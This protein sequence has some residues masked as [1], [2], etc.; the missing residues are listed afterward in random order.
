VQLSRNTLINSAFS[1]N[2][3]VT[4]QWSDG[5]LL[6][7]E[8]IG[9]GGHNT[10]RGYE[11]YSRVGDEDTQANLELLFKTKPLKLLQQPLDFFVFYDYG[12]VNIV[13]LLP[14]EPE[15]YTLSSVG[16]GFNCATNKTCR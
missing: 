12:R 2:Q 14:N 7:S 6:P 13:D 15:D 4:G 9:I 1:V 5:N 8:Q 3:G 11:K 10:V 16:I